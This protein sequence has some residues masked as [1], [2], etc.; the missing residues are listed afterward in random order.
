MRH[1]SPMIVEEGWRF[2]V[3]A[4]KAEEG[5]VAKDEESVKAYM[6]VMKHF[7]TFGDHVVEPALQGAMQEEV[8]CGDGVPKKLKDA[9]AAKAKRYLDMRDAILVQIVAARGAA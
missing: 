2:G 8:S 4:S 7:A 1:V 3:A 9:D 6:E 5:L